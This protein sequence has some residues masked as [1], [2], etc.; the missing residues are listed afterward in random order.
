MLEQWTSLHYMGNLRPLLP[1]QCGIPNPT[2]LGIATVRLV[3]VFEV[4]VEAEGAEVRER[5]Q[6]LCYMFLRGKS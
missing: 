5:G 2:P 3:V 4:E 6:D 1:S